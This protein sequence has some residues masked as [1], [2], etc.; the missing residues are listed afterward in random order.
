[1]PEAAQATLGA[2]NQFDEGADQASRYVNV[3]AA[4][5]LKGASEIA[6]TT[7]ALQDSGTAMKAAGLSFEQGNALIQS[8]AGVMI[9]GS[10][11]GTGLRNVLLKLE[12]DTDKN[13]RP[14]IVGLDKALENAAKKYDTTTELTKVFGTENIIAARRVLDTRNEIASLTKELTG[15]DV[16]YQQ[17]KVNLNNLATDLDK[18]GSATTG[19]FRTLGQSQDGLLRRLTQGY[20]LFLQNLSNAKSVT[21]IFLDSYVSN[22]SDGLIGALFTAGKDASRQSDAN[23]VIRKRNADIAGITKAAQQQVAGETQD[24]VNLYTKQG[25]ELPKA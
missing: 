2:L 13:L 20:T 3:L 17:Q 23:E 9:K 5:A 14:S 4:G 15:T 16:A 19:F 6:D 21:R 8:L 10:E 12:T 11:A 18:A 22:D 25:E 24:L 7:Q 1:M